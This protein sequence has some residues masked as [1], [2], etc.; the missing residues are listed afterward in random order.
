MGLV[1]L[2]SNDPHKLVYRVLL[3]HQ[4]FG[5]IIL[6]VLLNSTAREFL[7]NWAVSTQTELNGPLEHK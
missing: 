2:D 4:L 5:L 3:H 7:T 1:S 6:K